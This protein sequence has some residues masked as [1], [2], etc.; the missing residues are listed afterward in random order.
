[1]TFF[2]GDEK[3]KT[4]DLPVIKW[5]TGISWLEVGRFLT[6]PANTESGNR[7]TTNQHE[8]IFVMLDQT[9]NIKAQRIEI[10]FWSFRK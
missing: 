2:G 6:L 4:V 8:L 9:I 5:M 7:K 3:R 1:M 10:G